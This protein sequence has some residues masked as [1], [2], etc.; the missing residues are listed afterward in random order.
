[1]TAADLWAALARELAA[2]GPFEQL[3]IADH[4]AKRT[5]WAKLPQDV[6]KVIE[7]VAR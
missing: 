5:P 7:R 3:V 6:R 2:L 4:M 1:M